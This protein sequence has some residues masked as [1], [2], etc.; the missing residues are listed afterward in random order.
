M[1]NLNDPNDNFILFDAH[2]KNIC[3]IEKSSMKLLIHS[4]TNLF[5]FFHQP[6][7]ES[8]LRRD[9]HLGDVSSS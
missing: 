6:P 2:E 5:H 3:F 8:S 9:E 1:N 7:K 4:L